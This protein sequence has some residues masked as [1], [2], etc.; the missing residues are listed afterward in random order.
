MIKVEQTSWERE[1]QIK[2]KQE[3]VLAVKQRETTRSQMREKENIDFIHSN[4]NF[5]LDVEEQS[6]PAEKVPST[7]TNTSNLRLIFLKSLQSFSSISL[8]VPTK[9]YSY[10]ETPRVTTKTPTNRQALRPRPL[11]V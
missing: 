2:K 9:K 4:E 8:V 3:E 6:A 11:Q 5:E 10:G 1:E 7:P